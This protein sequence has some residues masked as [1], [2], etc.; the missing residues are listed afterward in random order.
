MTAQTYYYTVQLGITM[1]KDT[2][3]KVYELFMVGIMV[4]VVVVVAA[5]F[6]AG[7]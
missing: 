7:L 1:K 5:S 4:L 2:R 3:K 6:L